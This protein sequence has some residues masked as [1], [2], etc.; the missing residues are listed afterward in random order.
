MVERVAEQDRGL[1][2]LLAMCRPIAVEGNTLILGFDFDV[3][4]SKFE[5]HSGAVH[6]VADTFSAMMNHKCHVRCVVTGQYHPPAGSNPAHNRPV[7]PA[8]NQPDEHDE[9]IRDQFYALAAE[10]GGTVQEN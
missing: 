8:G 7:A 9:A 10:L 6:M 5:E 3:L 2:P 1:P 4:R